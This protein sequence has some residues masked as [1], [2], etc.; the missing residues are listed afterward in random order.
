MAQRRDF[1]EFPWT[2]YEGSGAKELAKADLL[3]QPGSVLVQQFCGYF[4]LVPSVQVLCAE[5]A[6]RFSAGD[7]AVLRLCEAYSEHQP[8][9]FCLDLD[10]EAV[11]RLLGDRIDPEFAV[12]NKLYKPLGTAEF[13]L[14][15]MAP[16]QDRTPV[17]TWKRAWSG[18]V[19]AVDATLT[20]SSD[21]HGLLGQVRACALALLQSDHSLVRE[22]LNA[23]HLLLAT[24]RPA[25]DREFHERWQQP[26]E[27]AMLWLCSEARQRVRCLLAPHA[28][29]EL[30]DIL[31]ANSSAWNARL[32]CFKLSFH[33]VV[34]KIAFPNNQHQLEFHRSFTL[35]SG[36]LPVDESI[37]V[38]DRVLRLPFCSKGAR[39]EGMVRPLIPYE[40]DGTPSVPTSQLVYDFMVSQPS[41]QAVL[42]PQRLSPKESRPSHNHG[43]LHE[44]TSDP[45]LDTH[46]LP[47]LKTGQYA[48]AHFRLH[49]TAGGRVLAETDSSWC[50]NKGGEHNGNRVY[51]L[52]DRDGITQRC[53][54]Q[55]D[56]QR[57]YG[58]C[59]R[60]VGAPKKLPHSA[61][62]ALFGR[63]EF[64]FS[65]G[66][67]RPGE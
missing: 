27:A 24:L 26:L 21:H 16:K 44:T 45:E 47:L 28:Q 64:P 14:S 19:K 4:Y 15:E 2:C 17:Y 56:I 60:F 9:K 11:L 7:R 12:W 49:R 22:T 53:H 41:A 43:D 37:L 54:C 18:L 23:L 38:G 42:L 10:D 3:Q 63:R 52:I 6:N 13:L 61:K 36:I 20:L 1:G 58:L 57:K 34:P 66:Q 39:H 59:K 32:L 62:L 50:A 5:I 46:L 30:K 51:F 25:L 35:P 33:I 8:V 40:V 29:L 31:F 65:K 48:G 55:C 67:V